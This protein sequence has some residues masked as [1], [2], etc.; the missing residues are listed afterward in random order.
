VDESSPA[1]DRYA[2][3]S[4]LVA[5]ATLLI[6]LAALVAAI[7]AA[8]YGYRQLSMLVQQ[9]QDQAEQMSGRWLVIGF[10]QRYAAAGGHGIR[11]NGV[12]RAV[13]TE[14]PDGPAEP[15]YWRLGF[16]VQNVGPGTADNVLVNLRFP[17]NV[18]VEVFWL[19]E[20]PAS[21][22]QREQADGAL[23]LMCEIATMH[24]R[25]HAEFFAKLRM[26]QSAPAEF[27]ILATLSMRNAW[28]RDHE[29]HV[30]VES[31]GA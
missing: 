23:R 1:A 31:D 28:P 25:A 15:E 3:A 5:Y 9:Q 11:P 17:P 10:D 19:G 2:L 26:L 29:L 20:S 22:Q 7:L 8:N 24:S 4:L 16:T 30:R 12:L 13:S 21:L 18:V 6:A 14:F 27:T